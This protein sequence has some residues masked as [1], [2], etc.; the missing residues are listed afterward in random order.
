MRAIIIPLTF[1][2]AAL[3]VLVDSR[4]RLDGKWKLWTIGT[5][6]GAPFVLPFYLALRKLKAGE[7]RRGGKAFLV[8]TNIPTVWSIGLAC[9]GLPACARIP[10]VFSSDLEASVFIYIVV[11]GFWLYGMGAIILFAQLLRRRDVV[12]RGPTRGR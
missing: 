5:F 2:V 6:L 8:A 10:T 1:G 4:R 12:E 9:L 7:V 11:W 3:F